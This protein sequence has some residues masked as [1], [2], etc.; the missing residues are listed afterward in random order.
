MDK[1]GWDGGT[2]PYD[3]VTPVDLETIDVDEWL[4]MKGPEFQH[5]AVAREPEPR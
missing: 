5:R 3:P 2:R 4:A 1:V